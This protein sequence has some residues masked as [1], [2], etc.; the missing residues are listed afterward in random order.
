MDNT[1]IYP[2][3]FDPITNG[4]IDIL[5]RSLKIFDKIIILL[6]KNTQKKTLFDLKERI[7][8]LNKVIQAEKMTDKVIVE[9]F[10][11]LLADYCMK[12]KIYILIR[13]LRPLAD[14]E[15]EFEMAMANRE[16]NH[17]I[18][19]IFILTDQNYFYLRSS[20]IKDVI[21]LGGDISNKIPPSIKD[22]VIKKIKTF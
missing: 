18:E 20:L 5:K 12:K 21:K 3:S 15:Y 19:T 11:G 4:H 22:E 9:S 16:L 10:D 7:E 13:G 17:N 6:A 14:F 8:Q 2:G 1:A